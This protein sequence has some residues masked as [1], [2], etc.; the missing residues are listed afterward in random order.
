M[1]Y[2]ES[3][4][5]KLYIELS[6]AYHSKQATGIQRVAKEIVFQMLKQADTLPYEIIPIVY[7]SKKEAF[8]LL[9]KVDALVMM[10][11]KRRFKLRKNKYLLLNE[12][13]SSSIFFDIDASWNNKL[14]RSKLYPLLYEK[15]IKIVT[16]HYDIVPLVKPEVV[17]KKTVRRFSEHLRLSLKYTNMF[18]CISKHAEQMLVSYSEETYS[19]TLTTQPIR[20]GANFTY[21]KKTLLSTHKV[22]R[23]KKRKY[24]LCV[25]TVEPRKKQLL[26]LQA[27]ESCWKI[28]NNLELIF[29]GKKGWDDQGFETSIQQNDLWKTHIF[30]FKSLNDNEL[31]F[32][33]EHAWLSIYL[34]EYEGYGLPVVEALSYGIPTIVN[35]QTS[36]SLIGK[37]F[38]NVVSLKNKQTL[39]YMI[40]KFLTDKKYYKDIKDKIVNT[41]K[42]VQW[43]ESVN[44]I[45]KAMKSLK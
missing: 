30:W 15:N 13:E 39:A 35:E 14:S 23:F 12:L 21:K 33:Y 17:R 6:S 31:S 40:S 10:F 29:V 9:H 43:S 1:F 26:I 19:K 20:L 18:L 3:K 11:G 24:I 41:Y 32:L 34:S 2:A 28:D 44:D 22:R 4:K 37:E 8:R 7:N 38:V 5:S 16:M 36:M 25:G 45:V 42:P 27:F